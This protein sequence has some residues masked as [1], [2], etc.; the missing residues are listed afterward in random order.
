MKV[1]ILTVRG[2]RVDSLGCYGNDWIDTP[3]LDKFAAES[4]VFD[5]HFADQPDVEGEF[6]AWETGVLRSLTL[7]ARPDLLKILSDARVET[8]LIGD[9]RAWPPAHFSDGFK[10]LL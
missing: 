7:P 3:N 9:G 2:L 6:L 8:W 10:K 5:E 4:V 1:L